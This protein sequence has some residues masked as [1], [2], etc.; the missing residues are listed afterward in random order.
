MTQ[1]S[2]FNHIKFIVCSLFLLGFLNLSLVAQDISFNNTVSPEITLCQE[3][4]TF[5]ISFT[6]DGTSTLSNV[7]VVLELPRGMEYEIGS[8]GSVTGGTVTESNTS[9]LQNVSFAVSDVTAGQSLSFTVD[10]SA[11]FDAYTFQT[12]GGIFRNTVTVN[13]TGGSASEETKAY[14]LLYPAL[15]IT[16]VDPMATTV[17]VGGTYTRQVTIVN[18]GYGKLDGFV[19]KDTHNENLQLLSVDKGTLNATKTEI[20]FTASDFTNIGDGDAFFEQNEA[21]TIEQTI[22]ANGCEDAESTLQAFWSC[23]GQ[24][25]GSNLKKP[26]T[27]IQLFAPNL[28][29]T[30]TPSFNTCVDGS[31]DV[32]S[33]SFYNKGTGPANQIQVVVEP[34]LDDLYTAIDPN[35]ITYSV[36]GGASVRI[37]PESTTDKASHDCLGDNHV[38]GFRLTLPT[39]APDAT[40]DLSWNSYTCNTEVCGRINLLSWEYDIEYTDMCFSKTYTTGG[41]GQEE[42]YKTASIFFESP[43]DLVDQQVGEYVFIL[44]GVQFNL[45][46]GMNPYFEVEFSIPRGLVWSGDAADLLYVSGQAEW[47]PSS[48]D[49]NATTRKLVAQYPFNIPSGYNLNRSEFRLNLMA[50]CSERINGLVTVGMQFSYVMDS[51]CRDPYKMAMTCYQTPMTYLHCPGNCEHGLAFQGFE[52]QRTS[53]GQ[54]D[55]NLD[56][57]PDAGGS[58][59]LSKIKLNRVM[60]KDTF[61]TIFSGRI[62]TSATYP[63]WEYGYANSNIPYGEAVELLTANVSIVDKSTGTT[64]RCDKVPLTKSLVNSILKV[65]ADFSAPTLA[66]LGCSDFEKFVFEQ[67]DEITLEIHYTL[68]ENLG[69]ITEQVLITNDFYVSPTA[70]GSRFQCNDWS[71]NV[72]FLGYYFTTAHVENYDIRSCTKIVKQNFYMSIGACCNNYAGGDFFPYEYRNW[73]TVKDLEVVIPSGYT[74]VDASLDY[75]RTKHV[76]GREKQQVANLTPSSVNGE[77]YTYDLESLFT[78]NGGS[79]IPSDDG[80]NGTVFLELE[81]NCNVTNNTYEEVTYSYRFTEVPKLSGEVTSA[82]KKADRVRY[83]SG[84]LQIST[85]LKTVEGVDPTVSWDITLYNNSLTPAPNSWLNLVS[86]NS[87]LTIQSVIDKASGATISPVNGFYQVAELAANEK[88]NFTITA[89]YN[90][91]GNSDIEVY[92]GYSCE[93][94]PSSFE[95]VDCPITEFQLSVI[96]QPSE[97]QV[98]TTEIYDPND[99]CSNT[100]SVEIEL[101]SSKLAA[102]KDIVINTEVPAGGGIKLV[103]GSTQAQYPTSNSFSSI[104]D[105]TLIRNT[106]QLRGE[107]IAKLISANGLV[108]ITDVSSNI[109]RVRMTFETGVDFQAGDFLQFNIASNR[110]CGDALPTLSMAYDPNSVFAEPTNTGITSTGDN[111]AASWG[112]YNNDGH[113]DLFVTTYDLNKPNELFKNNGDGTFSKVTSGVIAT[114]KASSLAASWAD[115]DND[116]DLDLYVANNIGAPNFLYR[117]EGGGNFIRMQNDPVV[118]DLGYGHGVSWADYDNDGYLDLFVSSFFPTQFNSLYHNNGDGTFS[119]ARTNAVTIEAS[120]TTAGIW[121]D[122]NKDGLIDL[123]VTNTNKE[124]N[125]LYENKGNGNFVK[126]NAGS[127]VNDGGHSVGASWGDY[128]NDG[129]LDIFVA[130]AANEDNFFYENNGNGTF[131]KIT[132]G[133]IVTDGGHSHGSSW[134]DVDNDGWLDLF[135]AN[136]QGQNNFLYKNNGDKTFTPI[137]NA[138]TQSGGLSF[139]AAWADYDNDGG[140]D[141][142]VANR[143]NT[144]NFLYQNVK[145]TCQGKSCITLMGSNSNQSAIGA[146]LYVTTTIY[147]QQ[148]T[149]MRE[150]SSQTGGGIGG[151]NELRQIIGVGDAGTIENITV[152]WPS[153][154]E[155]VLENQ[156]VDE[157]IVIKEENASAVCGIIYFD[158]N[159]N[160]AQDEDEQGIANQKVLL[161]PGNHVVFTDEEGR[162]EAYLPLGTFDIILEPSTNWSQ[163]CTERVTSQSF[164]ITELGAS[165]CGYDFGITAT[166]PSP[167]LEVEAAITAHRIGFKNLV[168]LTYKNNGTEDA[169]NAQL[170]LELDPYC[171][172]L[173]STIPWDSQEGQTLTW[174]MESVPVGTSQT[175]YITDSVSITTPIGQ[176]LSLQ[177]KFKG[178]EED[179]NDTNNTFKALEEAIGA[180]DPNDILVFPEGAIKKDEVITY[181]IRFQNV[182]NIPVSLVRIESTLPDEIDKYTFELGSA[183][184]SYRFEQKG[185]DLFW[186]FP[187]INLPDS[188]HNE[189]ESHGFVI[190][191]VKPKAGLSTGTIIENS[192]NI[193][194][195][196]LEE[197]PTNVVE[198]IIQPDIPVGANV[199]RLLVYPNPSNGQ[200]NIQL[201][202]LDWGAPTKLRQIELYNLQGIPIR[203]VNNIDDLQ[204]LDWDLSDLPRGIYFINALDETGE[205]YL[206]KLFLRNEQ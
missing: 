71:G 69:G 195:D 4:E 91:C 29:V 143:E 170:V 182:G 55:N 14:N 127:I 154:Y 60:A 105:P 188:V 119:K 160:C 103:S 114:D 49:Y 116:G 139:G 102:V 82:Y 93:G 161:T 169:T 189:P 19:L 41:I 167:D 66:G 67:D 115:Y 111:W 1:I 24:S 128:D 171:V 23:D 76:N 112:D 39:I 72:T 32:Q 190:F 136:D 75:Y 16:N 78:S 110:N 178:E 42:Q 205:E 198:S 25:S 90:S 117:N 192:A 101:L 3:A 83:F 53:F 149:Q 191:R 88:R 206:A 98:R 150:I 176:E 165:F 113:V 21:I 65:G 92:S 142:F 47:T 87:A 37:S 152:K 187:N 151:Q 158:K 166:C 12:S 38:R 201:N 129:D 194:F 46:E 31:P 135:V 13:Y 180:L 63:S 85:L 44:S 40:M 185:R 18:G 74:I 130:N 10:L 57:L 120:S 59:D 22:S 84:N 163:S 137:E 202:P 181:K 2:T 56:G 58:L 36:N 33:L 15:T 73:S 9:N 68:A 156:L 204:H 107:D 162:Y 179:C 148:V 121:G 11:S 174:S 94:Y 175:I 177:A 183:S 193:Y 164:N 89:N 123:F 43:S 203:S 199:G 17:F 104:S 109:V 133:N 141:L 100:F 81:P 146:K 147:G 50:D 134:A 30:P 186:E 118:N 35:S 26:Y 64:L 70:N 125:S 96:P 138:I 145:A 62:L 184:H 108:G 126:V 27:Q 52:V 77:T 197:V 200:V 131:T 140:V 153:G 106:Y 20:S 168:A 28:E 99:P 144:E 122:Y 155:Q 173:A 80:Y 172:P 61:K 7:Q 34:E 124:N 97:L 86:P 6:N 8:I 159:E 132:S 45:P 54:A 196:N 51:T 79:L 95:A 48:V 5:T 157:C